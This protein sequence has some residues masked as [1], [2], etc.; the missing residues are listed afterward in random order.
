MKRF[1][2]NTGLSDHGVAGLQVAI[3]KTIL[4]Q[5]DA[6]RPELLNFGFTPTQSPASD[7]NVTP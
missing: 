6:T 3:I 1:L 2:H 5:D 4:M 7:C